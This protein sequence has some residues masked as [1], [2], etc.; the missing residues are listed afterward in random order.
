MGKSI[1]FLQIAFGADLRGLNSGLKKAQRSI[2]RFGKSM[3]RTG[4]N[5]TRNLT[6]PIIGLGAVAVKS[7][8]SFEQSMLKVKAVSGAT[9]QE[10]TALTNS[11]KALGASTMF[12]ATQV[13][14]LQFELSKLGF[15]AVEID[16]AQASILAL[17]QATTHDLA[18]SGK[19]VASTLKSFSKEASEASNITDVFALAASNSAMD[20]EK[21]AAAMPTIGSTANTVGVSLEELTSQMMVLSD[22]GIEASTMGTH[23]RKIFAELAVKGITF[24]D[25]MEAINKSTNKV[26]TATDLFG[27]RAFNTGI[28]LANTTKEQKNFEK[29]LLNSGG[30][31][32]RMAKIMDSGTGGALRRLQSALEGVAI[33]LGQ[34][35]IP[36][37]ENLMNIIQTGI[38]F[39]KGLSSEV[40]NTVVALSLVAA[41]IGPILTIVGSLTTAFAF[42]MTPIGLVVGAL[43]TGGILIFKYWD[44]LKQPIVDL[45]NFFIELY[46]E[47]MLVRGAV[48]LISISFKNLWANIKFVF[49]LLKKLITNTLKTFKNQFGALGDIILGAFTLDKAKFKKGIADFGKAMLDGFT[50]NVEDIKKESE[51]LGNEIAQNYKQGY[52]NFISKDKIEF[53]SKDDIDNTINK[54]GELAKK[55]LSKIKQTLGLDGGGG[56]GNTEKEKPKNLFNRSEDADGNISGGFGLDISFFDEANKEIEKTIS[57]MDIL[58]NQFGISNIT[59]AEFGQ[60]LGNSLS[61]GGEDFKDFAT[62]AKNAIRETIS[63]LLSLMVANAVTK[64]MNSIPPFPGSVFLIPALAGLASGLAKTAF[65]SL[66]PAFSEGGIISGPTLGLMGEYSGVKNNPEV[67]APLDK[68]KTYMNNGVSQTVEVFGRISGNDIFLSNNKSTNSRLRY[69]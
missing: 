58:N 30:T 6:L 53:I 55:T 60:Q 3:K 68:L 50:D 1:G 40:R 27:K 16:K 56:G 12:T 24:N 48:Q 64:A 61:Q 11:A 31:A 29:E 36:L 26:K 19:I 15:S 10:F 42:L 54:A 49:N 66:I 35:L 51:I 20:M 44:D 5:L 43:V 14:E 39:W 46:N 17:S 32:L 21:F 22:R 4:A 25:A 52:D 23:L 13:S 62:N 45:V 9:E 28:I 8:M 67:V 59:L 2:N 18:E 57:L 47:S 41:A 34:M 38:K 37:F 63:G 65:N 33:D 7:F 69:V